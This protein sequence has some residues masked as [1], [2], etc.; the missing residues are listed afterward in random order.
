[1]RSCVAPWKEADPFHA[2]TRWEAG[3][4]SGF[5]R[6]PTALV[7][8]GPDKKDA[9]R[10]VVG[11]SARWIPPRRSVSKTRQETTSWMAEVFDAV[12]A[13]CHRYGVARMTPDSHLGAT[14]RDELSRRCVNVNERRIV[15]GPERLLAWRNLRARINLGRIVLPDDRQLVTEL[16]RIRTSADGS[17][18]V[19]PRVGDS[20]CDLA[21]ALVGAVASL[22]RAGASSGG[23]LG[24]ADDAALDGEVWGDEEGRYSDLSYS[25][26]L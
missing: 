14:V 21:D 10:L 22:D 12:A 17:S 5:E 11:Y 25:M 23:V 9:G 1:V 18:I 26:K 4:D 16:L 19:K 15:A 6:D 3:L 20:H 24:T 7:I 13:A 8:V 2:A